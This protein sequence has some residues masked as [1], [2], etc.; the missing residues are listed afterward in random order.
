MVL[1]VLKAHINVEIV[2]RHRTAPGHWDTLAHHRMNIAD[3]V[4]LVLS[5]DDCILGIPDSSACSENH[6]IFLESMYFGMR[7]RD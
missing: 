1:E 3:R 4:N 6:C 7:L 2:F 5:L